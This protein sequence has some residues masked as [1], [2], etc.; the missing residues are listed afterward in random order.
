MRTSAAMPSY[1]P[2]STTQ[3]RMSIIRM[4]LC[5][6]LWLGLGI[7]LGLG[8]GLGLGFGLG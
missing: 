1:Q 8:S 6:M 4:R 7:R 3:L 5:S 2:K